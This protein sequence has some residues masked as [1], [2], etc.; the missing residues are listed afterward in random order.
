[1]TAP[2]ERAP[3]WDVLDV[4]RV[5]AARAQDAVLALAEVV[6]DRA[7]DAHVGEEGGGQGEMHRGAAEHPLALAERRRD[8]V[9]GDRS[10]D[11]DAHGTREP[12]G[13]DRLSGTC[14]SAAIRSSR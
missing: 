8:R 3:A 12:S 14:R 7:H 11:G 9:E 1:M 10:N 2:E 5:D 4:R 6:A 13:A